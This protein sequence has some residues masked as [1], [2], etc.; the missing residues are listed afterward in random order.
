MQGGYNI[1]P[2]VDALDD[3]A[4]AEGAADA[5][6]QTILMFDAHDVEEKAKGGNKAAARDA[7]V[8]GR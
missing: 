2:L 5:L 6:S 1:Q 8:G 3:P 7:V 4:L